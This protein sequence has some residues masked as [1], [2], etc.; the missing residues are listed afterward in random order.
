MIGMKPRIL[1]IDDD[2]NITSFLKRALSYE[3]YVVDTAP[4]GTQGLSQALAQP[5]DLIVLD[6]MMPGMD[7]YEVATRL[8]AGGPQPILMLTARDGVPDRVRGLDTGADDY[9]VKPFAL[10]ELLARVRALLRRTEPASR[11]RLHFSDLEID[12]DSHEVRRGERLIEL[13]STEFELLVTFMRHPRQVLSRDNLLDTVW[14][15]DPTTDTHVVEV[16]IGYLRQKL[17]AEGEPRLIQTI[18]GVGYVLKEPNR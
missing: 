18:R 3:G 17:E 11:N 14:G 12:L 8:R 6:V 2:A 10:D 9:L 4:D 7:G 15:L 1:V 13:T 5:P 16:Y